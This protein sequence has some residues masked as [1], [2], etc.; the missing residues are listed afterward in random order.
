MRRGSGQALRVRPAHDKLLIGTPTLPLG[1][2]QLYKATPYQLC[3]LHYKPTS[4]RTVYKLCA[5]LVEL[6]LVQVHSYATDYTRPSGKEGITARDYYMLTHAGVRYLAGKGVDIPAGW[7]PQGNADIHGLFAKHTIE[8]NDVIIAAAK[9]DTADQRFYLADF[10]HERELNSKPYP[11]TLPDGRQSSV[12]PDA[13]LDFRRTDIAG[14]FAVLIEHD[15]GS[16]Q[17]A[18]FK[19]KVRAYIAY[20]KAKGY[21]T[22]FDTERINVAFTTFKGEA[23]MH[24]LRKWT[25][26]VLEAQNEPRQVG[27]VFRFAALP[28]PLFPGTAWLEARWHYA[29]DD[30]QPPQPLIAA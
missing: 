30:S 12:A 10:V 16:E 15:R 24:E 23:H 1:L 6:G 22:A 5:E 13:M 7:R 2:F 3:G 8:L 29:F 9:L 25:R 27:A 19:R 11:V 14:R 26:E 18:Y 4:L 28:Q 20:I 17:H 21:V